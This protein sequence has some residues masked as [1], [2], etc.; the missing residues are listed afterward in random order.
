[1]I[2]ERIGH[3]LH[4]LGFVFCVVSSITQAAPTA[5]RAVLALAVVGD[6]HLAGKAL[7]M[8]EDSLDE[9]LDEI[10]IGA[11]SLIPLAVNLDYYYIILLDNADRA[12]LGVEGRT[13]TIHR[14]HQSRYSIIVSRGTCC[15]KY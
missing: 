14:F 9:E 12:V 2:R 15:C 4:G 6:D 8:I 13:V 3:H 10:G 5:R 1:L 11:A 7:R